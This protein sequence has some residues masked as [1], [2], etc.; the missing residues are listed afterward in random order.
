MKQIFRR[1]ILE[2]KLSENPDTKKIQLLQ[3]RL[4]QGITIKDLTDSGLIVTL[5]DFNA[6]YVNP[7]VLHKKCKDV[8][9]YIGGNYIQMLS[10]GN[11]LLDY[12]N[13]KNKRSKKIEIV[14]DALFKHLNT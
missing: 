1:M 9:I 5:K 11:F 3:Q 14:E 8:M 10:D 4:D 6:M 12:P 13:V 7:P 2:E